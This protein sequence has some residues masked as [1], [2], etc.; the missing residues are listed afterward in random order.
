MTSSAGSFAIGID[1]LILI[2]M[3]GLTYYIP[4]GIHSE[5]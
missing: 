2:I 3:S 5:L 4:I 1:I